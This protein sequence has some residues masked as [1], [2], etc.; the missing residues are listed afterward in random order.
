M[1]PHMLPVA[2][3]MYVFEQSSK[4]E[5]SHITVPFSFKSIAHCAL[6]NT[7]LARKLASNGER[8]M[9]AVFS[10]VSATEWAHRSVQL[11]PVL[12]GEL[13][14]LVRL[15]PACCRSIIFAHTGF[16]SFRRD[17]TV[18]LVTYSPQSS[19]RS[20][21]LL[22]AYENYTW[23]RVWILIRIKLPPPSLPPP[24]ATRASLRGKR[25]ELEASSRR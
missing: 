20:L 25:R 13:L 17:F 19:S 14:K 16:T 10:W 9:W 5:D 12:N 15:S 2:F 18:C 8:E 23:G 11:R 4:L 7:A 24:L 22:V 21:E 3:C 1:C 6:T